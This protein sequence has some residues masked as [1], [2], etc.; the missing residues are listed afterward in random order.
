MRGIDNRQKECY[1]IFEDITGV[2]NKG[3]RRL[4]C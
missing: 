4:V 3:Y 2:S 1:F